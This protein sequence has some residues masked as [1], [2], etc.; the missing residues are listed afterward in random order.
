MKLTKLNSFI[1]LLI[2][3]SMISY[4]QTADDIINKYIDA[5][6][7]MSKIE[8]IRTVKVTGKS[9]FGSMEFPFAMTYKLPSAVYMEVTM[10]GLT[11]KRAYDGTAGWK[12]VPFQ[13]QKDPE[14]MNEGE[15]K[16]MKEEADFNGQLVNYKSKG[17]SVEFLGKEDMEGSDTYKLKVTNKDGDV[18]YYYL[19][20]A[21]YLI[22]KS[23][24][25]R[26]MNEKE[27]D[28]D[29]YYSDYKTIDGYTMPFAME[30]KADMGPMGHTQ[31]VTIESVEFNVP[32]DDS[33]FKMP[34]VK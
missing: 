27:I 1:I 17:D 6:G 19:D 30:T 18:T 5:I 10:Q 29:T 25:K 20:T 22:L 9:G 16:N 34:E 28:M 31:K 32:V 14:K 7:G 13:G 8:S 3:S 23:S 21:S 4:S 24:T 2:T 12:I 11:M 26:K 33:I 15:I